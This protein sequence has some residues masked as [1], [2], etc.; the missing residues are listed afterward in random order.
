MVMEKKKYISFDTRII[1]E[2]DNLG[3]KRKN[4]HWFI[5]QLSEDIIQTLIFGHNTH[6]Q[7]HVRYY[8]VRTAIELPVVLKIAND[9]NIYTPMT[10]LLSVNIGE[11]MPKKEYLEWAIGVDTD[12]KHDNRV[13]DSMLYHIKKYAIPFLNKFSTTSAIVEGIKKR[14]FVG[15]YGDDLHACI[16][17]LL[18]GSADDF[19]WFVEKRSYEKQFLDID[20]VGYWDY[21][22]PTEPL[23][24]FCKEFLDKVEALKP[25]MQTKGISW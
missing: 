4:K 6:G 25:I 18:Y 20:S 7:K 16:A 22:N 23:N 11:L 13:V 17:L 15:H 12:K 5:R 24:P 10:A 1:T 9:L 19:L 2:L 8:E 3:F 21:K 14:A